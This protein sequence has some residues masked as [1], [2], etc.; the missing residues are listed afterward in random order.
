MF[1]RVSRLRA[2]ALSTDF[3]RVTTGRVTV[4]VADP[5]LFVEFGSLVGLLAVAV[6][7]AERDGLPRLFGSMSAVTVIVADAP[8]AIVPRLQVT[9]AP[10]VHD[11]CV[12]LAAEAVISA[13]I[14][15]V[16][17]TSAASDG[18]AFDTAIV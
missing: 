14:G 1:V 8:A 5:A 10:V 17:E 16:N 3:A 9:E 15:S 4:V 2:A 11:P 6:L 18:P 7:T 13:G 12:E